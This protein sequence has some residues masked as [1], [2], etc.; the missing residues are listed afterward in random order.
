MD[1]IGNAVDAQL[2]LDWTRAGAYRFGR[3][4]RVRDGEAPEGWEY[5]DAGSFRSV[6]VSPEGVAYKVTHDPGHT[7]PNENEWCSLKA[8][9]T[10]KLPMGV[11]LPRAFLFDL[12]WEGR[13][14]CVVAMERIEG[15]LLYDYEGDRRGEYYAS[16]SA[17]ETL[18]DLWDLHDENAVVDI[19][20]GDIVIVDFSH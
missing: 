17:C 19:V 5:I 3:S 12:E 2:I 4:D 10:S 6:W 18:L 20:S 14:E 1:K 11:R 13:A 15:P 8:A 16:L 9:W 7:A